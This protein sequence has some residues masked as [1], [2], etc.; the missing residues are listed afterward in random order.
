[1]N[2]S[3]AWADNAHG[4]TAM[5]AAS[6]AIQSARTFMSS[7]LSRC[8]RILESFSVR[9]R[10]QPVLLLGGLPEPRQAVRLDDQKEDD[11][12]AED[13]Q[14]DFLRERHRHPEPQPVWDIRE[15]DRHHDDE[16]GAEERAEDRPEPADDD[17]E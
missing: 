8:D 1:M 14:F 5:A 9:E 2:T 3:A 15:Q 16:G 11:E 12:S 10:P 17:H 7:S 6:P 13:H 4:P